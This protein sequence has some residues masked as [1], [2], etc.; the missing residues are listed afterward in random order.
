MLRF[1]LISA[2]QELSIATTINYEE[3]TCDEGTAP[4]HI[5][6]ASSTTQTS[7]LVYETDFES[8]DEKMI[9]VN[10]NLYNNR[11]GGWGKITAKATSN[12]D[13]DIIS[14]RVH[15]PPEFFINS[16]YYDVEV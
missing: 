10:S 15:S 8:H 14:F 16:A 12:T 3:E 2:F 4:I 13:D 6:T 7:E 1:L 9:T 11:S 5:V